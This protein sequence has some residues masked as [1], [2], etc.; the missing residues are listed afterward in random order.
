[1][2]DNGQVARRFCAGIGSITDTGLVNN[3]LCINQLMP[4]LDPQYVAI[5]EF[6]VHESSLCLMLAHN[7]EPR[8]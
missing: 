4:N 2:P 3:I 7:D 5:P 1:M 6:Y 8:V